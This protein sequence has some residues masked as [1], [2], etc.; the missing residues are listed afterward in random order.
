MGVVVPREKISQQAAALTL[1]D[2]E[3]GESKI[4]NVDRSTFIELP[5]TPNSG[6]EGQL[7]RR[8]HEVLLDIGHPPSLL[9]KQHSV[10]KYR[11]T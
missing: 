10:T 4:Q 8:R 11:W 5:P 7:A 9:G 1:G 6:R 3:N 2:G